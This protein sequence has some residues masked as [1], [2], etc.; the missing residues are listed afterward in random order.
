MTLNSVKALLLVNNYANGYIGERNG[1]K[2]LTLVTDES[3]A[4]MK[5]YEGLWKKIKN[6]F[7][8]TDNTSNDYYGKY[9]KIRLI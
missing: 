7:R 5:K 8:S 4:T 3:K 6:I 1:N 2:Y 9:V